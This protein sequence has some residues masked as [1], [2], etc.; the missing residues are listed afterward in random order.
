[1]ESIV[2][3]TKELVDG[4]LEGKHCKTPNMSIRRRGLQ[5]KKRYF[6]SVLSPHGGTSRSN[7][8]PYI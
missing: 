8:E 5:L 7:R 4:P 1:M 2:S 3:L 6:P